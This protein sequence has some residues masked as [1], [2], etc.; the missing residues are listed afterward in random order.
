MKMIEKLKDYTAIT[1]EELKKMT[2]SELSELLTV[3]WK[4]GK[5]RYDTI[6]I[7]DVQIDEE[8]PDGYVMVNWSNDSGDPDVYI[9]PNEK[10][11]N[12]GD[13]DWNYG[14]YKKN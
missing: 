5:H 13:G 2:N 1:A 11:D 9:K 14:L 10:I 6:G 8:Q 3:C 12:V 4:R 7:T